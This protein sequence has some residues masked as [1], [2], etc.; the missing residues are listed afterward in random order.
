MLAEHAADHAGDVGIVFDN[1]EPLLRAGVGGQGSQPSAREGRPS[2]LK[3]RSKKLLD[4]GARVAAAARA[5]AQRF[6]GSFFQKRTPI[7][8]C[9]DVNG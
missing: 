3:K 8:K 4:A 7:L 1:Q 9:R 5:S 2:F 6:F